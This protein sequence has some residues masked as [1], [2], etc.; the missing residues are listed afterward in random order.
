[1]YGARP[2]RRA[3]SKWVED[4]IAEKLLHVEDEIEFGSSLLVDVEGNEPG[5]PQVLVL[6]PGLREEIQTRNKETIGI[7]TQTLTTAK[8]N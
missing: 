2:L 3:I 8:A 6:P 4:P 5:I 7:S 1:M